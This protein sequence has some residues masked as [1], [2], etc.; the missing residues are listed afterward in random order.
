MLATGTAMYLPGR[1]ASLGAETE[2]DGAGA[3]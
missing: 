1:P 3:D 2:L